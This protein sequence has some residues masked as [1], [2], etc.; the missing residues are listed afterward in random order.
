MSRQ[1][2]PSELRAA[3]MSVG[4]SLMVSSG[5]STRLMGV[6][7][8]SSVCRSPM[9][10]QPA[11]PC[12]R[13]PRVSRRKC[14]HCMP[15]DHARVPTARP[16]WGRG[17]SPTRTHPHQLRCTNRQTQRRRTKRRKRKVQPRH[18]NRRRRNWSHSTRQAP[19]TTELHQRA[20]AN[21]LHPK[22]TAIIERQTN[23]RGQTP[24]VWADRHIRSR[25]PRRSQ[26]GRSKFH[27]CGTTCVRYP[28]VPSSIKCNTSRLVKTLSGNLKRVE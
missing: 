24:S 20:N 1:T 27:Y 11:L 15:T 5:G 28:Q 16:R 14:G 4:T 10:S 23:W 17:P 22:I 21:I 8:G 12:W 2:S 6:R 26:L 3:S 9:A 7:I 18:S 25:I 13:R 19:H